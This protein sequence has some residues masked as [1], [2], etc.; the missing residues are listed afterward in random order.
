MVSW[1]STHRWLAV[2]HCTTFHQA[3]S[4]LHIYTAVTSTPAQD[5]YQSILLGDR[6]TQV[7]ITCPTSLHCLGVY[8][9]MTSTLQCTDD[10]ATPPPHGTMHWRLCH[11]T[12]TWYNTW[13]N[14]LL[15][16]PNAPTTVPPHYHMVQCTDNCATPPP[17][18]TMHGTMHYWLCHPTT[19]WYNARYNA[20]LTVPNAPTTVPSHYHMVQWMH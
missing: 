14:A 13:Y 19:T 1:W 7:T 20:L 12:T 6:G 8:L 15:T 5:Q 2:I 18:G 4:Y 16:V 3:S 11:P 10:C 9:S 17:H